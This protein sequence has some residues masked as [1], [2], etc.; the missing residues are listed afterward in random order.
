M[1]NP[2][3]LCLKVEQVAGI[4]QKLDDHQ[5]DNYR[6]CFK[7]PAYL[8]EEPVLIINAPDFQEEEEMRLEREVRQSPNHQVRVG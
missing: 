3:L 5:K 2:F 8:D 1:V 6:L 4:V 7:R